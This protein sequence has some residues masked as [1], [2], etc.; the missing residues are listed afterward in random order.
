MPGNSLQDAVAA[1]LNSSD[2][3][4]VIEGIKGAVI[5]EIEH[6]DPCA[7]ITN[8]DY[9][10]HSYAPDLVLS[11]AGDRQVREVYL[12]YNLRSAQ[13]ARDVDLLGGSAPVFFSLDSRH[14]DA[15]VAADF[16][17]E[18]EAE[19]GALVTNAPAID[20]FTVEQDTPDTGSVSEPLLSLFRR[21]VV[22]GGRGLLISGTA[23]RLQAT[24]PAGD[25][26]ADLAYLAGFEETITE[27]FRPEAATRLQRAA[28]IV[29]AAR[30]GDTRLFEQ[31]EDLGEGRRLIG[32][33]LETDELRILL[34]YLLD[35]ANVLE[36]D[37]FWRY[38][39]GMI[40]LKQLEQLAETITLEDLNHLVVANLGEWRAARAVV[41]FSEEAFGEDRPAPSW[42]VRGKMLAATA[43]AWR[44]SFTADRR[45]GGSRDDQTLVRWE[46]VWPNLSTS[47]LSSVDL[48]GMTRR[49]R[50]SAEDG[51]N[52]FADVDTISSTINDDFRVRSL[53]L[54]PTDEESSDLEL[55]FKTMTVEGRNAILGDL[56][57]A[58]FE[59]L[60]WRYPLSE[61]ERAQILG[62][63]VEA[64][65]RID[66]PE[67]PE[68]V[69]PPIPQ[70]PRFD[71]SESG[72]E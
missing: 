18:F 1:A 40:S 39:G 57:F 30:T 68:A 51:S 27:I 49:V 60:G 28:D 10:N 34:P 53:T 33:K 58:A 43:G 19:S 55:D 23:Q 46:D 71:D 11:W 67:P 12:R 14:D 44:V 50:V 62:A 25:V 24:P 22:R 26:E 63:P 3:T 15:A 32:G 66:G 31:R 56:A 52:V 7:E 4:D 8:T 70:L 47:S 20:G 54:H 5:S 9:F 42:T 35:R 6:L 29:R 38:V 37:A 13:A 2:Q 16:R 21:N 65:P 64:G 48:Q 59:V 69:Q 72:G 41:S 17:G 36:S 45:K 61:D